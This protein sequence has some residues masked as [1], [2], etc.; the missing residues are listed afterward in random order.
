MIHVSYGQ[1][2]QMTIF[3]ISSLTVDRFPGNFLVSFKA[4]YLVSWTLTYL[5]Q[6]TCKG[7]LH[8]KTCYWG[9]CFKNV[10]ANVDALLSFIVDTFKGK[11]VSI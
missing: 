1:V 6:A 11:D 2:A 3:F 10:D 7:D 8:R 4:N 9:I 5:L